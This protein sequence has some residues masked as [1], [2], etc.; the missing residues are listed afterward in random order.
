MVFSIKDLSAQM[1]FFEILGYVSSHCRILKMIN[2]LFI[3]VFSAI[4][5]E[6]RFSLM[7]AGAMLTLNWAEQF[8][9]SQHGF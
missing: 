1:S 7:R 4:A 2:D 5:S 3:P 6:A 9:Q 8:G